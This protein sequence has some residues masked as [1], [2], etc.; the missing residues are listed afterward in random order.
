MMVHLALVVGYWLLALLAGIVSKRKVPGF[1]L[2]WFGGGAIV[3]FF[4]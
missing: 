1:D 2:P 3:T 4:S